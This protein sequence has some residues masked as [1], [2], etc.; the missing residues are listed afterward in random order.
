MLFVHSFDSRIKDFA[1]LHALSVDSSVM[2]TE[3]DGK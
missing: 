1:L 2:Y 3:S